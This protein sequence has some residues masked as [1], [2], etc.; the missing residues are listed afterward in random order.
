MT[1]VPPS[2]AAAAATPG[3][4]SVPRDSQRSRLSRTE[5]STV[6]ANA[7]SSASVHA[8]RRRLRRGGNEGHGE[9]TE[10][11]AHRRE[12]HAGMT[13]EPDPQAHAHGAE[14]QRRD[15]GEPDRDQRSIRSTPASQ[16]RRMTPENGPTASQYRR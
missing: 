10:D 16:R 15:A 1:T 5:N 2:T 4:T 6:T 14:E 3:G 8:A 11:G 7:Y 9:C 12:L 13:A